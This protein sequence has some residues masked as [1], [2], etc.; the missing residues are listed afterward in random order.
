MLTMGF[1]TDPEHWRERAK[2]IRLTAS[3]LTDE[4]AKARM[5]R[6]AEGYEK[7]R[8]QTEERIANETTWVS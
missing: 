1:V 4:H 6:I 8:R 7:L 5:L 3:S 2:D